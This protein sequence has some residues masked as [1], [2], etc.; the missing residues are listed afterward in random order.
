VC[1][2]GR[3]LPRKNRF[4]SDTGVTC[5]FGKPLATRISLSSSAGQTRP[6]SRTDVSS[7]TDSRLAMT[8]PSVTELGYARSSRKMPSPVV[9][10]MSAVTSTRWSSRSRPRSILSSTAVATAILLTLYAST[11]SSASS[12]TAGARV[13]SGSATVM[14]EFQMPAARAVSRW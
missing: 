2:A 11:P 5:V 7:E 14:S 8:C 12:S 9:A 10:T 6:Q 1:L 3:G 4:G 13:P